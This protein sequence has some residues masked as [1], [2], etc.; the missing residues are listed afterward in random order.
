M[1]P[2]PLRLVIAD[3]A[4]AQTY[5]MRPCQDQCSICVEPTIMQEQK[6]HHH[7]GPPNIP[8]ELICHGGSFSVIF[9]GHFGGR[10]RF[11]ACKL[12]QNRS[13]SVVSGI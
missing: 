10:F 2:V 4:A 1:I 3:G 6:H 9:G 13:F 8:L 7:T 5:E 11:F 12:A